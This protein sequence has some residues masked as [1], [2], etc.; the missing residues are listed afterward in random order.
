MVGHTQVVLRQDL[1]GEISEGLSDREGLLTG[2]NRAVLVPHLPK[3]PAHIG[4]NPP[5]SRL[6]IEGLGEGFSLA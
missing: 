1:Q 2:L 6:V 3:I 5:Q 4:G